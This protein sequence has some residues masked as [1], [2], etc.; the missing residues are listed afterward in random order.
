MAAIIL[1][2]ICLVSLCLI[3]ALF[4]KV[5]K[6]YHRGF[7]CDDE[8]ISKPFKT[9]TVPS[10]I[11]GVVGILLPA[12]CILII[13]VPRFREAKKE[14]RKAFYKT[15]W[16]RWLTLVLTL[17]VV[18]AASTTV[19]TDIGKYTVGRLRPHFLAV[20]KPDFSSLNCSSGFR[21]N[22]ITDYEC[23]GDADV[24]REARLSFPSGHSSF[25]AYCMVFLVLYIDIRMTFC[26]HLKLFKPFLQF[27]FVNMAIL[28]G[29]SRVSDYKHHWSDVLTGL[30][31]GTL[32]AIFFVY[33]VLRLHHVDLIGNENP[34]L[35][36]FTGLQRRDPERGETPQ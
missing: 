32:V 2:V 36:L 17:F 3:I 10:S 22:F 27:V 34:P 21:K 12:I 7:F 18:G 20:C 35:E 26:K 1:N 11:A 6:P 31:L 8:S 4:S 9:G 29:L 28:C 33:R 5:G 15:Q 19:L 24:I 23:T 25:G 14:E 16:C 30:L 13:E